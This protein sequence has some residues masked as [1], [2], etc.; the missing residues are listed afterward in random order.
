MT[1]K[2]ELAAM[3]A[4]MSEAEAGEVVEALRLRITYAPAMSPSRILALDAFMSEMVGLSEEMG[5]YTME[6]CR[7]RT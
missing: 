3:L 2:E 4:D 1:K 5:G 7:F 6:T